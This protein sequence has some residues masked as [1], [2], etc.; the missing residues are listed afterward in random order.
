MQ[1]PSQ[2]GGIFDFGN[3]FRKKATF[4]GLKN[5]VMNFRSFLSGRVLLSYKP[6]FYEKTSCSFRELSFLMVGTGVEEFLR[7]V[8]KF[9]YP[10]HYV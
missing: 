9:S 2:T 10:I 7:E 8:E 1:L 6:R 5:P 4:L 3:F